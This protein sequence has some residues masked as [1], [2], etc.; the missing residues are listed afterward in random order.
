[1]I[2]NK[3]PAAPDG[4]NTVNPFIITP[5]ANEVIQFIK[6]VFGGIEQPDATT[7]DTDGLLLHSETKIGN[8]V[9]IV[10]DRKP[11]WPSTP[12]L[13]QVYVDDVKATLKKAEKL[14][15]EVVTKPTEFMGTMFAR[16]KDT[17]GNLWWAYQ[18]L[19]EVDWSQADGDAAESWEP[20]KEATYIHDTL[21]E[22]MRG[23]G[24]K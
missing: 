10:A 14:G 3:V 8:S 20:T 23:L 16:F 22:A 5:N 24:G 7:I 21:L 13:L 17:Q 15:A 19:G 18:Y 2:K 1:M 9:V 4:Y 6:D 12:S 11:D